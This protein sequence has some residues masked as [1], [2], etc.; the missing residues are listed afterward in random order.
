MPRRPPPVEVVL[1]AQLR[2]RDWVRR[3]ELFYRIN[4]DMRRAVAALMGPSEP[5]CGQAV[6]V[7]PDGNPIVLADRPLYEVTICDAFFRNVRA[8]R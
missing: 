3:H 5:I 6:P 4:R 8:R 2:M 7:E 1:V